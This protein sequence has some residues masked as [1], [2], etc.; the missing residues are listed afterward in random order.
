MRKF[1]ERFR[2]NLPSIFG[3]GQPWTEVTVLP[4]NTRQVLMLR[5]GKLVRDLLAYKKGLLSRLEGDAEEKLEELFLALLT[6]FPSPEE[7]DRYLGGAEAK[8]WDR[9]VW[10]NIAWTLVNS[11]EFSIRH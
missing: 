11:T 2:R 10:E 9:S 1:W 7:A 5:N 8:K 3:A 6:R 4:G